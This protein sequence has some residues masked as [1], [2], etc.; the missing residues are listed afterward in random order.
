MIIQKIFSWIPFCIPIAFILVLAINADGTQISTPIVASEAEA[1]TYKT[2]TYQSPEYG[3]ATMI[4]IY[5]TMNDDFWYI[6]Y[7]LEWTNKIDLTTN[8][9]IID[10]QVR[11]PLPE[12]DE[13]IQALIN[14]HAL[15]YFATILSIVPDP[16]IKPAHKFLN[17]PFIIKEPVTIIEEI[18]LE[19]EK[20]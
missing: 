1:I 18:P 8:V 11:K 9:D 5:T 12:T 6:K 7:S 2:S 13:E 14:A 16:I 10:M 3:T 4:D 19:P 20:I 17:K 15:D